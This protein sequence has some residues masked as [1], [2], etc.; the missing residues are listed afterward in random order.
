MGEALDLVNRFFDAFGAGDLDTADDCFDDSC[1][2]VM[3]MGPMT[4]PDHRMMGM[5]FKAGLPDGHMEVDHVVDNGGEVFLEGRFVGT[6]SGD[7]PTPD[8]PLPATG[9]KLEL[10]FADYFKAGGGKIVEHRTYFDQ[11]AMMGQLTGS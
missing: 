5:A 10:R 7:F 4:K 3:P 8:G 6:H 9:D 2:F 11:A 1:A